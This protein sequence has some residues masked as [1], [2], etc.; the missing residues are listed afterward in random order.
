M[1]LRLRPLPISQHLG[2]LVGVFIYIDELLS[3]LTSPVR[4]RGVQRTSAASSAAMAPF[5]CLNLSSP[6]PPSDFVAWSPPRSDVVEKNRRFF[7]QRAEVSAATLTWQRLFRAI[8]SLI[9]NPKDAAS[10]PSPCSCLLSPVARLRSALR[11]RA[12]SWP[13]VHINPQGSALF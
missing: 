13:L 2:W 6:Q 8:L 5:S 10:L 4:K 12:S 3:V 1:S 9:S 7:L 11:P